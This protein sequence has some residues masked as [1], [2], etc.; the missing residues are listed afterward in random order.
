[1]HP[2]DCVLD[3]QRLRRSSHH[4]R[5][6]YLPTCHHPVKA[7][8]LNSRWSMKKTVQVVT[9]TSLEYKQSI[10]LKH[11]MV[12]FD[13]PHHFAQL[14]PILTRKLKYSLR[15]LDF[16]VTNFAVKH[17][18]F[19]NGVLIHSDYRAMLKAFSKKLFD[20]FCRRERIVVTFRSDPQQRSF[21]TTVAQ[22]AFFRWAIQIGILEYV[23]RHK[24]II[25]SH[26]SPLSA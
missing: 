25:C 20:P 10:L 24:K 23:E 21:S 14:E 3:A 22:L 6:I 18:V 5:H 1:M 9:P 19:L 17:N 7:N 11:I 12:Y 4:R 13:K 16:F 2:R 26:S 8:S 15:T